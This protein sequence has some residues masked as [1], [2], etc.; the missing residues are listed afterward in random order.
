MC[1]PC[2][3]H[4]IMC[5]VVHE[6]KTTFMPSLAD[7]FLQKNRDLPPFFLFDTLS[8][9]A[10]F[11]LFFFVWLHTTLGKNMLREFEWALLPL[12]LRYQQT[13]AQRH[14]SEVF[15]IGNRFEPLYQVL[16]MGLDQLLRVF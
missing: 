11:D 7:H 3:Q 10:C 9:F 5:K 2:P 8:C 16:V 12:S 15:A 1:S 4:D 13:R 14:F 6:H